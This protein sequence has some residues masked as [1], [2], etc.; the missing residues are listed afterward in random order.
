[1][2]STRRQY[3]PGVPDILGRAN[4]VARELGWNDNR[5]PRRSA[6]SSA[7]GNGDRR[8][9]SSS[10]R[11]RIHRPREARDARVGHGPLSFPPVLAKAR[12]DPSSADR[13]VQAY[14]PK[15]YDPNGRYVVIGSGIA[16]V[17]EW[18]NAIDV[19]AKVHLASSAT[20]R[21]TS[22]T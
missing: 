13:I 3:N 22:R 11:T 4:V 10:T 15:T 14:E 19:G 18:A 6:G 5:Y 8:I 7:S 1:M 2:R 20:R 9:S 16:S 12:Q 21:R 17:N